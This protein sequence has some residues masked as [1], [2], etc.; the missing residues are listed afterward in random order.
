MRNIAPSF[1]A[2]S[3]SDGANSRTK[4]RWARCPRDFPICT[5]LAVSCVIRRVGRRIANSRTCLPLAFFFVPVDL[6]DLSLLIICSLGN[7]PLPRYAPESINS[8]EMFILAGVLLLWCPV[9]QSARNKNALRFYSMGSHLP[10]E[11]RQ[12]RLPG[13]ER[14]NIRQR[15]NSRTSR[16]LCSHQSA[17]NIL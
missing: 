8:N 15:R 9:P 4:S 5:P 10:L 6:F 2:G 1:P 13:A 12:A 3:L 17:S 14:A 11:D 7:I 16:A